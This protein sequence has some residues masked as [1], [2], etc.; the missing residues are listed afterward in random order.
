MKDRAKYI[1]HQARHSYH[2]NEQDRD[3]PKFLDLLGRQRERDLGKEKARR[4]EQ[5][6]ES[7]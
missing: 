1:R 3:D 7:V 2:D 6:I 5:N 4:E